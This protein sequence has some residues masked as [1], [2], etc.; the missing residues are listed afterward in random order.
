MSKNLGKE[1]DVVS[2]TDAILV[3]GGSGFVGR[4]LVKAL[5]QKGETVVSMYRNRLPDPM[6][7][8]Y[9][10]CSDLSSTELLAAPL[11][12]VDTVVYLAWKGSF[13]TSPEIPQGIDDGEINS[14]N[15]DLLHHLM[16]AM[17]KADTR[18]II[19]LSAI[20][21]HRRSKT[22]FLREKY[23]AEKLVLNS[24]I[25]E[26]IIVRTSILCGNIN[27]SD[28]FL[29]SI[30]GIM[31][32]PGFYPAPFRGKRSSPLYVEDLSKLISALTSVAIS[33]P[34]LIIEMT[35][36]ENFKSEDLFKIIADRFTKGAKIQL[37]GKLGS[38]LLPVFEKRTKDNPTG[39]LLKDF[40]DVGSEARDS[41]KLNN[42]LY[43]EMPDDIKNFRD[44]LENVDTA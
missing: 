1:Q 34:A 27:G 24:Q 3:A 15:I 30:I 5:S 41:I 10:V 20:G 12:G 9:P 14:P 16:E 28:R 40:I 36:K 8:V 11:R 23:S 31:R 25:K 2:H 17:E 21:S 39:P 35:G 18:R 38:A 33:E 26:K 42:P 4:H 19:F 29:N 44:V 32:Y 6:A 22:P 43:D 7:N 13:I 37:K